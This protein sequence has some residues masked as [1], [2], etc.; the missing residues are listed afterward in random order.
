MGGGGIGLGGD[1]ANDKNAD[2]RRL[3][4]VSGLLRT[5]FY[6]Q[7]HNGSAE[8]YTD[9]RSERAG[10]KRKNSAVLDSYRWQRHCKGLFQ[11]PVAA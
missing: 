6:R 1:S 10:K 11:L 2:L 4:A 9:T 5:A 8:A 7:T 3:I